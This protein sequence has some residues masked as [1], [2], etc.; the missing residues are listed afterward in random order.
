[1]SRK[2]EQGDLHRLSRA[3]T[4]H[5]GRRVSYFARLLGWRHEA[6]NR[7]LVSLNDRGVLLAEDEGGGLWP[8]RRRRSR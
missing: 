3:I 8:F 4:D 7:R 2:A 1:M 6:V 5:P